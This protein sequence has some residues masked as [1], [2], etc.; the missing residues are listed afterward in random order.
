[1]GGAH[2]SSKTESV[3]SFF[4]DD[5]DMGGLAPRQLDG[6]GD[7]HVDLRD[8]PAG[9]RVGVGVGVGGVLRR[10]ST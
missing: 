8:G 5:H 9:V 6:G 2:R 3:V 1:M 10:V 7:A 4:I